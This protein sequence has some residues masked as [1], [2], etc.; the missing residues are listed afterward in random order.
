MQDFKIYDE[1]A[2]KLKALAHPHRLCIVKGLI[3]NSCNVTKIQECLDL[4]QSTVSQHLAKLKAA[5]I[6]EGTRNG[7]EICYKVVDKDIISIIEQLF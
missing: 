6:I 3:N 1:K 4:P 5:G 7:L 2:E